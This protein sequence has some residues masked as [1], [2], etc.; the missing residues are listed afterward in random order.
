MNIA[1]RK[2]LDAYRKRANAIKKKQEE[3]AELVLLHRKQTKEDF[4]V[5]EGEVIQISTMIDM[6]IKVSKGNF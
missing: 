2:K 4:G 1:V 5:C 6:I 3:L